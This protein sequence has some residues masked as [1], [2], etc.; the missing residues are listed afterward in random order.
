[1]A[2]QPTPQE[3]ATAQKEFAAG[4]Y[5]PLLAAVRAKGMT[6]DDLA[7]YIPA[8]AQQI[9]AYAN[10]PV[11]QSFIEGTPEYQQKAWQ[12]RMADGAAASQQQLSQDAEPTGSG[13][14]PKFIPG[15]T[16]PMPTG[17]LPR[18]PAPQAPPMPSFDQWVQSLADSGRLEQKTTGDGRTYYQVPGQAYSTLDESGQLQAELQANYNNFVQGN[19]PYGSNVGGAGQGSFLGSANDP[20]TQPFTLNGQQFYRTGIS[21][22]DLPNNARGKLAMQQGF[23]PNKIQYDASNGYYTDPQNFGILQSVN[24]AENDKESAAGTRA[25]LT[26]FSIPALFSAG[27]SGLGFAGVGAD[28]APY[29]SLAS[30]VAGNAT[31]QGG[32]LADIMS[33]LGIPNN[34]ITDTPWGVSPRGPLAPIDN[35]ISSDDFRL[36][37]AGSNTGIG[38]VGTSGTGLQVPGTVGGTGGGLGL[39]AI[40]AGGALSTALLTPE[41]LAPL[42]EG[43]GLGLPGLTGQ[44][45]YDAAKTAGLTSMSDLATAPKSFWDNLTSSLPS[46]IRNPHS[47]HQQ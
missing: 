21:P 7:Q 38:G 47:G 26:A 22:Q 28:G 4:D 33:K 42:G 9:N 36:T 12:Q 24:K 45:I 1:M 18:D 46:G 32:G 34:P 25:A 30:S 10:S 44:Q 31:S 23:D 5:G 39:G 40:G 37:N 29:Q 3:I 14:P 41:L 2:Y 13:V 20:T 19:Q 11:G 15:Q 16:A 8:T 27:M 6:A 35:G 43:G 17:T